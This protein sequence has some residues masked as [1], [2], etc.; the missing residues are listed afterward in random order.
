MSTPEHDQPVSGVTF[1]AAYG[2]GPLLV[3]MDGRQAVRI[4]GLTGVYDALDSLSDRDLVLAKA[5]LGL[6]TRRINVLIS[7]RANAESMT[8]H[9]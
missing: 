3:Y 2:E 4:D 5:L 9:G 7:R 1:H 8:G 6:A